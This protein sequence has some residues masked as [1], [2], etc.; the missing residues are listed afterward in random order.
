MFR[1]NF[2]IIVRHLRFLSKLD[3]CLKTPAELNTIFNYGERAQG[4][5]LIINTFEFVLARG[6]FSD[7]EYI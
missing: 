4:D 2:K 3:Y 1:Q 7:L 5:C 6:Q